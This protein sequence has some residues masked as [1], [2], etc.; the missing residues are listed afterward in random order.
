MWYPWWDYHGSRGQSS[1]VL[2]LILDYRVRQPI[3]L[4]LIQRFGNAGPAL[5]FVVHSQ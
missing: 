1:V 4:L 2:L 5:A 3:T